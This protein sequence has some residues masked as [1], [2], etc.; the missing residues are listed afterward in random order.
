MMTMR[1]PGLFALALAAFLYGCGDSTPP[2]GE[3]PP[4]ATES[5]SWDESALT[6]SDADE[7]AG[8][9]DLAERVNATPTPPAAGGTAPVPAASG[10]G[11]TIWDGVYTTAQASHGKEVYDEVCVICHTLEQWTEPGFMN[12]HG[13]NLGELFGFISDQMSQTESG[14]LFLEDYTG[15]VAYMLS[16]NGVPAGSRALPTNYQGLRQVL[17]TPR[18]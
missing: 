9:E 11:S 17:I 1:N 8:D 18:P 4:V 7:A 13:N 2:A 15:I 6:D 12:R 5:S 10:S 16:L 3:A 14:S